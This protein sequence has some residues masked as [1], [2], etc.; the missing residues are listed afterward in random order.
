MEF[1]QVSKFIID[2]STI[3]YHYS[4]DI[5]RDQNNFHNKSHIY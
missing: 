5:P 2:Q 3:S 1:Y 4:L